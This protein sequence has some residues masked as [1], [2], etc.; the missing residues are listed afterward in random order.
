MALSSKRASHSSGKPHTSLASYYPSSISL[1]GGVFDD[2]GE[3]GTIETPEDRVSLRDDGGGTRSIVEKSEFA[4]G[5]AGL[6]FFE[7]LGRLILGLGSRTELQIAG[8]R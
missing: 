8:C 3:G 1:H 7:E 2:I 4:E 5:I 6:I